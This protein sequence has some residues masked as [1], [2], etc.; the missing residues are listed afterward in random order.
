LTDGSWS[1]QLVASKSKLMKD[2]VPRNE[3]SAIGV[4]ADLMLK[5][6]RA[7]GDRVKEVFYYS[8]SEVGIC[9]VLNTK[10]AQRMWVH[11]RVEAIRTAIKWTVGELETFPLFHIPGDQ[12]LADLL[13]KPHLVDNSDLDSDSKWQNGLPWMRSPL[14]ALPRR[15]PYVLPSPEL[16]KAYEDEM[17]Q[18]VENQQAEDRSC[19][20]GLLLLTSHQ[21]RFLVGSYTATVEMSLSTKPTWSDPFQRGRRKESGLHGQVARRCSGS[22]T[23]SNLRNWGG[24]ALKSE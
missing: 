22:M 4:L 5:V 2:T 14:D 7:L 3:L 18:L 19:L 20:L 1:C 12:N 16:V 24:N 11:N 15:Q 9:W 21:T 10:R 17:F 13:T 6:Q 8:D 23:P